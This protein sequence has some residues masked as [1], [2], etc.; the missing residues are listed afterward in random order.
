LSARAQTKDIAQALA[1]K[2][3][4][5]KLLWYRAYKPVAIIGARPPPTMAE[6]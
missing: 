2:T 3:E 1:M 6:I 4:T 5:D